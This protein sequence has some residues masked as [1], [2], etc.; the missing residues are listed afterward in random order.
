[1]IANEIGIAI[2]VTLP[3][4]ITVLATVGGILVVG[5]GG[6]LITPMR[7]RWERWLNHAE[8]EA[9][10]QAY[11]RGR[12]DAARAGATPTTAGTATATTSTSPGGSTGGP[13][14]RKLMGYLLQ[15]YAV[16]PS[17]A[18]PK[19]LPITWTPTPTERQDAALRRAGEGGG[20]T[21][22]P[23]GAAPPARED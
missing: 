4:L 15:K 20:R 21:A 7:Q 6:G 2:A 16:A 23:A 13:V 9:Q 17:G 19:R 22:G 14:F 3:V 5:V 10:S 18:R 11:Q 12:E 1:M 8:Q